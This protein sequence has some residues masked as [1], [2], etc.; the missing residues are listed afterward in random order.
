[1]LLFLLACFVSGDLKKDGVEIY[2]DRSDLQSCH[3]ISDNSQKSSIKIAMTLDEEVLGHGSGNYFK[4]GKHRFVLTAA[5]VAMSE[6]DLKIIDGDRMVGATLV[7]ADVDRD[8]AILVPKEDLNDV[9]AHRWKV[10]RDSDAVGSVVNYTGYPSGLGQV[11]IRGMV[12][13]HNEDGFVMQSFA[14]PGSSG[15]VVFDSRGRVLGVVSAVMLHQSQFSPFPN[16]QEN[17]VYVSGADFMNN[18]FIKEV[19]KCG[20]K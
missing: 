14:L 12:S 3:E 6:Y 2:V 20:A 13:A 10:N 5:H 15:S 19:L 7:F 8:I 18:K 11:L 17:I 16:L 4:L 9:K 1:M